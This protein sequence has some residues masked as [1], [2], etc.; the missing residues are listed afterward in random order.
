[1]SEEKQISNE[2]LAC[3]FDGTVT[4]AEKEQVKQYLASS[5]NSYNEVLLLSQ[6]FAFQ[7]IE[8]LKRMKSYI[9]N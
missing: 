4:E 6:E 8:K 2:L 5:E 3:Y 7:K 1:M 9:K